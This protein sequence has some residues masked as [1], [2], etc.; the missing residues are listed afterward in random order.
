MCTWDSNLC[1]STVYP[2]DLLVVPLGQHE[3]ILGM[4][5]LS[6]YYAQLDY[7]RGRITLEESGQPST[8]YYGICPSAGVSLVSALRVEKDLIEDEVYLVTL[9]TLGG[10][11][12]ERTKLEEITVVKEY[13]DVFQPLEGLPPP[14]SDPFTI[15]LEP[16]A[17]PIAKAPYRMAP[18]E[19]AELKKQLED[20]IEKRIY[21][22][23]FFTMGSTSLICKEERRY[24]AVMHRL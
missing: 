7:G 8:T 5:W 4:D 6:R 21:Q 12:N 24:H 19:L 22:T 13:Q 3:V 18:A 10:E 17:A 23:E 15:T 16:G 1:G 14:R 2:A 20:L 9:T 11:L